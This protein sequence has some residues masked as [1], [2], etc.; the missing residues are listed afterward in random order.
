MRS[1][2]SLGGDLPSH[3]RFLTGAFP[4]L[5]ITVDDTVAEAGKVAMRLTLRARTGPVPKYRT[6]GPGRRV[7][8]HPDLRIENGKVAQTW[9]TVDIFG[10]IGQLEG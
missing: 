7:H 1:L 6:H 2:L 5:Y 8:L 9:A 3:V 4:D 10:L